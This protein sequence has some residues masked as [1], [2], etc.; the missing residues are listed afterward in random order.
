[1][2]DPERRFTLSPDDIALLNPNTRTCPIFRSRKDAE[3]TKAIY[4]RVPVICREASDDHPEENPWGI[5]FRQGLFNMTSDSG[6][7]RSRYDLEADGWRLQG[8]V[9]HKNGEECLPLYEAKMIHHFDHRWA[10]YRETGGEDKADEVALGAKQSPDY[11]TLPRHWVEAREVYLRCADLPKGLLSAFAH[12]G[13]ELDSAGRGSPPVCPS[14]EKDVQWINQFS[15]AHAL[16]S[17]DRIRR[18][19]SVRPRACSDA[20]GAVWEQPRDLSRELDGIV[21]RCRSGVPDR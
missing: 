11:T 7:F 19:P 8:N 1:M 2:Y 5:R 13:N 6:L 3:L 17:V 10:S 4:R 18:A 15:T 21:Q 20:D 12:P 14:S 16:R 9:F